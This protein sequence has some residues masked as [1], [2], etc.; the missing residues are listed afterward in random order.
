M[1]ERRPVVQR[2]DISKIGGG[3]K[4]FPLV[5]SSMRAQWTAGI[6]ILGAILSAN[7]LPARPYYN[8]DMLGYLGV[9]H[10]MLGLDGERLR[11]TVYAEVRD[12]VPG[13]EFVLLTSSDSYRR[14]VATDARSFS[15]QLPFYAIKPLYPALIAGLTRAGADPVVASVWISRVGYLGIGL[16]LFLW[17][18]RRFHP[19]VAG[20]LAGLLSAL[21]FALDV[22]RLSTPD[23]VSAAVVLAGLALLF[24][25]RRQLGCMFL[26]A[27]V[28]VRPDNVIWLL[29]VVLYS[30]AAER[31]KLRAD[32]GWLAAGILLAY[33]VLHLT[34]AYP[35]LTHLQHT[36]SGH[37]AY[38]QGH[39]FDLSVSQVVR[40]YLRAS[41]PA[42]LPA[43]A[44][45]MTLLA[46]GVLFLNS[47][48][49]RWRDPVNAL[50]VVCLTHMVLHWLAMPAEQRYLVPAYL[51]ILMGVIHWGHASWKVGPGAACQA[52]SDQ[53]GS[54]EE[55]E[56]DSRT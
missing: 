32:V 15:Q 52:Q 1:F 33:G 20:A 13:Q 7:V 53:G 8:W 17:L 39:A 16:V 28:L 45:L 12:A 44:L 11:A 40:L 46:A 19:P 38:P 14:E 50:L 21:P 31:Q 30:C 22:A 55:P 43:H 41:H 51:G 54:D 10:R 37:L 18:G 23:A 34:G 26:T 47:P 48:V 36:M 56:S 5:T 9:A 6:L 25:D 4:L 49:H 2:R 29:A 24:S 42:F 3:G 27:S 35:W